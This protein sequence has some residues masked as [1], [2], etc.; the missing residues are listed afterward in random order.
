MNVRLGFQGDSSFQ[1]INRFIIHLKFMSF[2]ET[3][4]DSDSQPLLQMSRDDPFYT[5]RE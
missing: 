2:D 1:I 4:E 3:D 5:I